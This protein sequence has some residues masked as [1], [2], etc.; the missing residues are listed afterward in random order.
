[1]K[2]IKTKF[3][4]FTLVLI[5]LS[6]VIPIYF[7]ITQFRANFN[8]RSVIMLETTLDLLNYTLENTMI[9]GNQKS[10][11][12]VVDSLTNRKG[13]DYIR[14]IN[15]KGIVKYASAKNEIGSRIENFSNSVSSDSFLTAKISLL[16]NNIYRDFSP[17]L[18]KPACMNC[19]AGKVIAYLDVGANLTPA[20]TKFYTGTR[21]MIFLGIAILIIISTG[22]YFIF[23]SFINKPLK[24]LIDAMRDIKKGKLSTHLAIERD[25]EFGIVNKN[26]N[27][28]VD[29]LRESQEEISKLHFEQLQHADRL[30]TLGELT[31]ET[32][33]EINNHSAIIMSRA[34]YLSFEALQ[35]PEISKYS[36]DFNVILNQIDKVS[37]ITKN[38][39]RHSKKV[40]KNFERINLADVIEST[41]NTLQPILK[42]RKIELSKNIIP[43]ALIFGDSL[44][45]EQALTNLIINSLDAME[46]EGIL[47]ISLAKENSRF[48][49]T[50]QDTGSGIDDS[51][52]DQVFSPFFTT[53]KGGKGSGLGLYIVKNIC[54]NHNA[55][56]FL[57]RNDDKG[58]TFKIIFNGKKE[59]NEE[60]INS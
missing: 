32:A 17:I 19:H 41:L 21:H 51:I 40:E 15:P 2:T 30:I 29:R 24:K 45:I 56:I 57:Q 37:E 44:Q 7:L 50:V 42:K 5:I 43:E 23:Q 25:D 54:K 53:K 9:Q 46:Q 4:F 59:V 11:Q 22:F 60:N 14:I 6:L 34:D 35:T 20:E 28:M 55:E 26:F 18:N 10:L 36:D 38:V 13:I 58:T 49:I 33:H 3:I 39:L 31:S 8:Q 52:E 48:V 1:M 16:R 27:L 12:E 47:K